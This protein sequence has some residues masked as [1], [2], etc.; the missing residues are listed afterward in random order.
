MQDWGKRTIQVGIALGAI[1]GLVGCAELADDEGIQVDESALTSTNGL[2]LNG[3]SLN[4]LSLNGLSLNGLSLNGLSLNGLSTVAGL[5]TTSGMMTTAGGRD[6]VKYMVKCALP[7]GRTLVKGSYSFP[8]SIG[9]AP[10][11]ENGLCDVDCQ[12]KVSACMLAHVNNA[13]VNVQLWM[14]GDGQIGWGRDPNYQYEEGAFFGNLF[15][16]NAWKGYACQGRDFWTG[17]VPG[18]LGAPITS[19]V[20]VNPF[21]G[22][23]QCGQGCNPH[24]TNGVNDGYNYCDTNLGSPKRWENIVTVF[25]NFDPNTNY[26]ICVANNENTKCLA[27]VGNSTADGA[28]ISN[29]AYTGNNAQKWKITQTA[30]NQY[31]IINAASGRALDIATGTPKLFVQKSFSSSSATQKFKINS[32]S[33]VNQYGRY[34]LLT[35]AFQYMGAT[36]PGMV[37]GEVVRVDYLN[38]AD[39]GKW[40]VIPAN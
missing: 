29:Q 37:Q 20:Y 28:Q 26:K 9:V 38:N 13:G 23:V 35:D 2:S 15:T 31:K 7:Q 34:E 30:P 24:T 36:A 5:S 3:L 16:A 14:T 17:S 33:P 6:I 1:V 39:Y 11:W 19:S 27:S 8:G 4:G 22:G 12:E 25:R 10:Q 18:R 40:I 32:L 21:G